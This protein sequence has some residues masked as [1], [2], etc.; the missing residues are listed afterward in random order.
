MKVGDLVQSP[1]GNLAIVQ[2]IHSSVPGRPSAPGHLYV[3]LVFLSTGK[4]VTG[5][6]GFR[7]RVISSA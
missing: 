7:F 5:R 4:L 2:N 1:H 3:D 6:V